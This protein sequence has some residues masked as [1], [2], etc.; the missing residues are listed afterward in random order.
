MYCRKVALER[1]RANCTVCSKTA[2]CALAWCMHANYEEGVK[3]FTEDPE[4]NI[5][6]QPHQKKMAVHLRNIS[7]ENYESD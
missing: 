3:R 7:S 5:E 6:H 2:I 4:L 1:H